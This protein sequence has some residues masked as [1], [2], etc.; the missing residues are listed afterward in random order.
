MHKTLFCF[1]CKKATEVSDGRAIAKLCAEHDTPEN[2]ELMVNTPVRQLLGIQ[3][4]GLQLLVEANKLETNTN[5]D[6]V[7]KAIADI[8]TQIAALPT[9]TTI[10]KEPAPSPE[11]L[12]GGTVN[13]FGE[14]I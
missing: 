9:E 5:M 6:D 11:P 10:I 3:D 4:E 12:K 2:R 7:L 8:K 13:E 1:I 14:I